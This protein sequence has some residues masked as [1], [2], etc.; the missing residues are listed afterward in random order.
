VNVGKDNFDCVRYEYF[1]DNTASFEALKAGTY[2]FHEENFSAQWAT[3][4]DFPAL[5]RGWIVRD[6]I[7]DDRPSGAQGF[8][9]NLRRPQ[10][11]DR[12]VREAIGMMFNFEWSNET[13]FGGL[14]ERTDSFWENSVLQAE[15]MAEGDELAFL[16]RW[17]GRLPDNVFTDPAYTPPK[18]A[19][20]SLT[21]PPR[22]A[23]ARFWTRRAGKWATTGCAAML[24]ARRCGSNS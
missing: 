21:A 18:A 22:G 3:G 8:W 19:R 24:A 4:Y 2:L 10:F 16:E 6:T 9:L 7:P 14:Y 12:R 15:G 1:A 11:E 13:L 17:R 20:T 5:S 23:R